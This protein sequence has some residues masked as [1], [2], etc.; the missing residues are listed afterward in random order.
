MELLEPKLDQKFDDFRRSLAGQVHLP[1]DDEYTGAIADWSRLT[2]HK[3]AMVVIAK[4]EADVRASVKYA[5]QAGLPIAV[6]STGR[7]QVRMDEGALLLNVSALDHVE[8]D[9]AAQ[10][11]K[12]GGGTKWGKVVELTRA[13]NLVP[14][15]CSSP[16]LGVVGSTLGGGYGLRSR[17]YGLCVDQVLSLRIVDPHGDVRVVSPTENQNIYWAVLGGDGTFGV[18]TEI[19]FRL[20]PRPSILGGT[21]V[22]AMFSVLTVYLALATTS[23]PLKV[24]AWVMAILMVQLML[25]GWN[26]NRKGV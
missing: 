14:Y 23:M 15:S 2:R 25:E 9:A 5:G 22:F 4:T 7:G 11:A 24:S 21:A 12:I 19:E 26:F 8:I 20:H 1:G 3:P 6:Q 10:T 17:K 13:Q 16:A 18:V